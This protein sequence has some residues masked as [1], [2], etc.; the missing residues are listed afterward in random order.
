[1][2]EPT[3]EMKSIKQENIFLKASVK[4]LTSNLQQLEV[5]SREGIMVAE[6]L[7]KAKEALVSDLFN[8]ALLLV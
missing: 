1:M 8:S 5:S 3:N 2:V 6:E 7:K 4:E